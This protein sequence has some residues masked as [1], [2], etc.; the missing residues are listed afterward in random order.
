MSIGY[1]GRTCGGRKMN[2]ESNKNVHNKYSM[3]IRGERME[4]G[5]I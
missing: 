5:V 3:F 2:D 1:L 4:S